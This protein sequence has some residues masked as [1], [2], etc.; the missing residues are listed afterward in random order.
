METEIELFQIKCTAIIFKNGDLKIMTHI[1]KEEKA[2]FTFEV[3]EKKQEYFNYLDRINQLMQLP[4]KN[5]N[6]I[7]KDFIVQSFND[8]NIDEEKVKRNMQVIFIKMLGE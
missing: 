2:L 8:P 5:I 4:A 7:S 3:I 1:E 6:E